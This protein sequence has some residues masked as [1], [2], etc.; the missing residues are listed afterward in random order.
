[1]GLHLHHQSIIHTNIQNMI[2]KNNLKMKNMQYNLS[3]IMKAAHRKFKKGGK[4]FSECL[5]S[6]WK[7][8]KLQESFSDENVAKRDKEFANKQNEEIR[9]SIKA[10]PSKVY[11]DLS[12]P[13]SAYYNQNSTLYGAHY[14]GD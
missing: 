14:V 11:N 7:F 6:A 2:D 9:K 12:I 4:T 5:K 3:Q 13:V 10:T 1:M 8:A